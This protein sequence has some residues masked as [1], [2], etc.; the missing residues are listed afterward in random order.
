MTSAPFSKSAVGVPFDFGPK[1]KGLFASPIWRLSEWLRPFRLR[2]LVALICAMLSAGGAVLAPIVI[3]QV[4]IDHILLLEA[5]GIAPDFGQQALTDWLAASTQLQPLIVACGLDAF[6]I[7]LSAFC[8][9]L[10]HTQFAHA[11]L[12]ALSHLRRTLFAHVEHLPAAFYDRASI[13]Q[14]LTHITTDI[15]SLDELFMG[16]GS[17]AS[18]IIPFLIAA[19]I[20]LALDPWLTLELAPIIPVTVFVSFMFR[21]A[22]GELYQNIRSGFSHLNEYLH[23][24]LSGIEIIQSSSREA[25]NLARYSAVVAR[26]KSSESNAVCLETS[27]FPFI[28]NLSYLAL[29][30]IL[31]LGSLHVLSGQTTLGS[32]IL[33][34]QFSDMLF[35]PIAAFGDQANNVFRA[36]AACERIFRLL[37]YGEALCQPAIPIPLRDDLRGQIEFRDLSFR[38]EAGNDVLHHISLTIPPGE[39]IAIIGPTGSGK[40]T[41]L[42]LICRFYD[43]SEGS[44]FLNGVDVMQVA[45]ADIRRRVGII[46]Q[47][48][49]IFAGT[50]YENIALGNPTITRAVAILAAKTANASPFIEALP[51]GFDTLLGDRG[52]NLS[53]GQRQLLALARVIALDPEILILDEATAN[54]DSETEIVV[55]A[56]LAKVKVGRTLIVVAHKLRT[57]R[58]AHRIIVLNHGRIVEIGNHEELSLRG[59]LYK[60]LCDLQS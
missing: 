55:Q 60:T 33:F 15:E 2:M 22:T 9:Y 53:H 48:F 25:N 18:G 16:T 43:V 20:M 4:I 19:S 40:T 21:R 39:S 11:S 44:L 32:I 45:P 24:N 26:L 57:I 1:Q 27:Y 28:E 56:A 50:I 54:I 47:D 59:G 14:I 58:E 35:R 41:L 38:Y 30:V 6:W 7:T 31:W 52:H 8:G 17:L 34:I 23:E 42:R 36:R 10:F 37:D 51:N 3:S 49:H 12:L 29:G 46:F 13:G 5:R